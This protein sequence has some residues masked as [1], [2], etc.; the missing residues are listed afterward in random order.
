MRKVCPCAIVV[1]QTVRDDE[2]IGKNHAHGNSPSANSTRQEP[3]PEVN[4]AA[5]PVNLARNED[6]KQGQEE[7]Q[8]VRMYDVEGSSSKDQYQNDR[9]P[10]G[11]DALAKSGET[12]I[13]AILLAILYH[14]R[15]NWPFEPTGRAHCSCSLRK[16]VVDR[17]PMSATRKLELRGDN[18]ASHYRASHSKRGVKCAQFEKCPSMS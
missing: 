14:R 11:D 6:Q 8:L 17:D 16:G 7:A 10:M 18:P 15:L 3:L 5:D 4:H 9:A 1:G 2:Q 12:H 13:P